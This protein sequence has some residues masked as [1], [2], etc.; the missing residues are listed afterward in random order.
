MDRAR[1]EVSLASPPAS[2]YSKTAFGVVHFPMA[3]V[4]QFPLAASTGNVYVVV[5]SASGN[6][7]DLMA[8][9]KSCSNCKV[10]EVPRDRIP[11]LKSLQTIYEAMSPN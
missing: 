11:D 5:C 7:K 9:L 6:L 4:V 10:S 8:Q 2:D 3:D 1:R